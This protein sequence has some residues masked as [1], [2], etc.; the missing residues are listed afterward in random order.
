[1]VGT[2]RQ[3][4]VFSALLLG[5]L[6]L[7]L[8]AC[9]GVYPNSTFNHTSEYNTAIDELWDTLLMWG[10]IVF[11]FVE[12]ALV[13]TI[14]RF[15]RRPDGKTPE[16]VHGNTV[17]EITWTAIPA[18]IL[19]FIAIPTV[20]TIFKTQAKA[21]PDALQV[22]VIGHQWWWEFKY[23]Q[24]GITTAN[25]LYLPNGRTVNFE[26]KTLDV[27]HSFWIPQLG[28]KR[29]LISNK[30]NFLWFTPNKDLPSSAFNGFCA[31]FCGPSHA[32]MKFRVFTVTPAEFDQWAAHQKQPA[33][34]PVASAISPTG[35]AAVAP[36]PSGT[37]GVPVIQTAAVQPAPD[38]ALKD[39]PAQVPV[40][41]FPQDR[42]EKE[43]AHIKP[44]MAI[45]AGVTFDE[46]LIG[47]G[48]AER[49]RQLYSRSSCI[50]CHAI[51]GN[52]M[53]AG[54][55]GPNLTHI[56]SRYTI[57]AGLYPNDA[58]H[59]AYWLKNAPHL[60]PGSIMPTIGKGL[61]D[62]V[63]KNTIT[64]GGLTDAEIA[65]IVAYLQALK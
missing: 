13:Y 38:S 64:M 62:P 18:V 31:E 47:K 58:K 9:G 48:D 37:G 20:R 53:S 12:I 26:L 46:S 22:Q 21:A 19:I 52:A 49:G 1:M 54:V 5:A 32:N 17:L 44:T 8:A 16:Q 2:F 45:P 56:G 3:R 39:A 61:Y 11:I 40:W 35:T 7:G 27:L 41:V 10:T 6:A 57:A 24:L 60:K 34:F 23:P 51:S 14:F 33:I 65:D 30:S 29:D 42:L 15:R 59:L 28:G 25:E 50:G 36:V 63:R 43:F 4:R 55:I